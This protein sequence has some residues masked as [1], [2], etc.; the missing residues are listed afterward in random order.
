MIQYCL[1]QTRNMMC[2]S[3]STKALPLFYMKQL[4][5]TRLGYDFQE[6]WN[7]SYSLATKEIPSRLI[8]AKFDPKLLYFLR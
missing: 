1:W 2:C 8:F 7:I 3:H 6:D 5:A 4:T